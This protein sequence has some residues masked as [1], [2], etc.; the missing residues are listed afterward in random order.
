MEWWWQWHSIGISLYCFILP[1]EA[2]QWWMERY[3]SWILS[4][5]ATTLQK[6]VVMAIKHVC[7]STLIKQKSPPKLTIT[8]MSFHMTPPSCPSKCPANCHINHR[9]HTYCHHNRYNLLC[10]AVM[11]NLLFQI[12]YLQMTANP[13]H[14][15]PTQKNWKK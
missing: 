2:T 4:K 10:F 15:T 1:S 11:T 8:Y 12:M 5:C 14:F 13:V 9:T 3:P 6:H 7:S